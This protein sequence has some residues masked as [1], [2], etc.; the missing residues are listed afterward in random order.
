MTDHQ[1]HGFYTPFGLSGSIV[2]MDKDRHVDEYLEF[3][4]QLYLRMK[5]DRSWPWADS[6]DCQ[7][8]LESE[9]ISD[10]L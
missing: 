3:C 2:P 8:L 6:T 9:D 4:K 10:D 7:D 1:I 5:R